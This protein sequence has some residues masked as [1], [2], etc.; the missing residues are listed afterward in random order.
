MTQISVPG[1]IHLLGEHSVVY[2]KI[3]LLTAIN[4]RVITTISSSNK[5]AV[6][7]KDA[8]YKKQITILK[9]V[10]QNE[11]QKLYPDVLIPPLEIK[12]ESELPVGSGLGSSAALSVSL[13]A[14]ILEFL[15]LK[16]DNQKIFEIALKGEE[17]FHGNPSGGDIA[18][19]LHGGL[20]SFKKDNALKQKVTPLPFIKSTKVKNFFLIFSGKPQETTKVMVGKVTKLR[21]NRGDFVDRIFN[22]QENLTKKLQRALQSGNE[23][24]LIASIQSGEANLEAIG[25]VGMKA[26][27]IIREIEK[28]GGAG[29][30]LG[31]GGVKKGSGM[32]LIYHKSPKEIIKFAKKNNLK[33]QQIEIAQEGLKIYG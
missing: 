5:D 6:I 14:G 20:I 12:I 22:N 9:G 29:K 7:L 25:V 4:L 10:I 24:L 21:Q 11:I 18:A 28:I 16:A 3:A 19:C 33:Y 15:K 31:G 1:K 32:L 8:K 26:A 2:G 27:K 30:I 23:K 13:T 17:L